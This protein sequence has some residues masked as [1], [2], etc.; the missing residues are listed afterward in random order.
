MREGAKDRNTCR[1]LVYEVDVV[2][3]RARSEEM[4]GEMKLASMREDDVQLALDSTRERWDNVVDAESS[5]TYCSSLANSLADGN[6]T[7]SRLLKTVPRVV[8]RSVN[9]DAMAE[10][11]ESERSV[12]D[13]T[14]C[15]SCIG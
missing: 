4:R 9:V 3:G 5:C 2:R 8:M 14:F 7:I 15:S 13:E 12:D 11:L 1:Q 10:R 6:R